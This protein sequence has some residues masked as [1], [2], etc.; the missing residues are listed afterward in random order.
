LTAAIELARLQF[1]GPEV[2]VPDSGR[3]GAAQEKIVRDYIEQN[4][5]RDISLSDLAGLVSLS[6]FHSTRAFRRTTGLTPHQFILAARV[7]RAKEA[8]TGSGRS[9]L[10][11]SDSLGFGN[12]TQFASVF[13][14]ATGMTPSQFRRDRR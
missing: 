4:L 14:K 8:L 1:N 2:R 12:Q 3:L 13:R 9:M 6:R 5:H 11:I 7:E 10:E